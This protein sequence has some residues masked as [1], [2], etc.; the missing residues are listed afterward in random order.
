MNVH[1]S[2]SIEKNPGRWS[3][4]LLEGY[5]SVSAVGVLSGI[6]TAYARTPLHWPGHKAIFWMAPI[7]AARLV[8]RASAGASVGALATA[9]TTLFLGGRIAGGI[10]LMPLII[11]AGVV[12]DL[13]VQ[14]GE[15]HRSSLGRRILLL[16]LAGLIANLICFVKRLA[17]PMGAFLS[18]GNLDDLL[19]AGSS[20][21]I[22]GCISGLLGATAGFVL[23][24]FRSFSKPGFLK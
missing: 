5:L 1:G 9:I 19:V 10:T 13:G 18:P 11:L 4:A 7:L 17:E 15:R 3:S 2:A 14:L 20:H 16:V 22:F 8:T 24:K 21:A 23:L 12:L 6:V